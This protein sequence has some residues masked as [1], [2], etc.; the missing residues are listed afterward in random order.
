VQERFKCRRQGMYLEYT[1]LFGCHLGCVLGHG[2]D[3]A[4]EQICSETCVRGKLE[5]LGQI[6]AFEECVM[7]SEGRACF[8]ETA[9]N[10][11]TSTPKGTGPICPGL[12][13][14]IKGS[15]IETAYVHNRQGTYKKDTFTRAVHKIA[16]ASI[17]QR[18]GLLT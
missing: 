16:K 8:R 13:V 7:V 6:Y 10:L 15:V 12:D 17:E 4:L 9:A 5:Y 1:A 14:S 3:S 18:Q 2:Y 11:L